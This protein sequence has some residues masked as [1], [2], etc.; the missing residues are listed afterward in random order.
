[1]TDDESA[2]TLDRY[3][4]MF[5]SA[6]G[7]L[8]DLALHGS[9]ET[10]SEVVLRYDIGG[11]ALNSTFDKVNVASVDGEVVAVGMVAGKHTTDGETERVL[12]PKRVVP[13][14]RVHYIRSD[15]EDAADDED[16]EFPGAGP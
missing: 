11:D 6:D 8:N 5:E 4:D 13:L 16:V 1:M 3:E 15:M 9:P 7:T 12:L 2:E 14:H 10:G